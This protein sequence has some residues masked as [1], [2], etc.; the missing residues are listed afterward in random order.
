MKTTIPALARCAVFA[1]VFTV[2]FTSC[3]IYNPDAEMFVIRSITGAERVLKNY[4]GI[5]GGSPDHPLY[6]K[7]IINFG[8]LSQPGNKYLQLLEVIGD[9]GLYADLSLGGSKTGKSNVFTTPPL[10]KAA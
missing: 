3:S 7:V 6:L 5:L 9:S 4:T 8:D 10:D 1:A 2:F